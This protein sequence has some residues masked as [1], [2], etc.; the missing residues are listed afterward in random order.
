MVEKEKNIKKKTR[1]EKI[2]M[3]VDC[4]NGK[5]NFWR[6]ELCLVRHKSSQ[7]HNLYTQFP[8]L[9]IYII[10]KHEH[11]ENSDIFYLKFM[12]EMCWLDTN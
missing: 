9:H 2:K 1:I 10:M 5:E 6:F 7:T 12:D 11:N 8:N 4:Q 3:V